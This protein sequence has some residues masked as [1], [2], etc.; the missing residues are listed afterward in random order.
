MVDEVVNK[1]LGR[2]DHLGDPPPDVLG[3]DLVEHVED[4]RRGVRLA[5]RDR[6]VTGRPRD[7]ETPFGDLAHHR[8]HL[9]RVAHAHVADHVT[10]PP[11]VAQALL[12][13]LLLGQLVQVL[14]DR[15]QF[16]E[17]QFL[18]IGHQTSSALSNG[19]CSSTDPARI[20]FTSSDPVGPAER[21]ERQEAH[22]WIGDVMTRTFQ[23][24]AAY[25]AVLAAAASLVFTVSFAIVVQEGERWAQ[26]VS[27]TTLF[28]GGLVAVPV[29][30]CPLRPAWPVRARVR[31]GR[32]R[33]RRRR[34]A[35]RRG[36]RRLRVER[37]RQYARPRCEPRRAVSTREVS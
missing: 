21:T 35:G 2:L 12:V 33:T 26:W 28:V 3:A 24:F 23:R 29:V 6:L 32:V 9:R 25:S 22:R 4:L 8:R 20:T 10:D 14:A 18:V 16:G 15:R 7:V 19:S 11:S 31:L 37:A 5:E 27:W 13:P 34:G 1:P 17:S 36:A 30:T